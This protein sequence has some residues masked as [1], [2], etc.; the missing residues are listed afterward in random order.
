[1]I[2]DFDGVKHYLNFV[3][4]KGFV[5]G[6]GEFNYHKNWLEVG[7]GKLAFPSIGALDLGLR[8]FKNPLV[9]VSLAVAAIAIVTLVFYTA[10]VVA[11][12]PVLKLITPAVIRAALFTWSEMTIAG[13]GMRAFGR[14][15]NAELMNAWRKREV[16]PLPIGAV[17]YS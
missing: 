3:M 12:V 17:V 7:G 10:E 2:C 11:F 8:N 16:A 13:L 9:I 14:L 1:M 15:C 5:T 4:A 6:H